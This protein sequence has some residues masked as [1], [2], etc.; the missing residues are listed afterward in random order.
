[1][2][3]VPPE[4]QKL[5]EN[6]FDGLAKLGLTV[7]A[8][9]K[10]DPT[11]AEIA[12]MGVRPARADAEQAL[13]NA[14][15][16]WNAQADRRLWKPEDMPSRVKL[17]EKAKPALL[18]AGVPEDSAEFAMLTGLYSEFNGIEVFNDPSDYIRNWIGLD[19]HTKLLAEITETGTA[20]G[21]KKPTGG[22]A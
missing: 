8:S 11:S 20:S 6:L 16:G 15:L 19:L 17:W 21:G 4:V 1:M 14:R 2:A 3:S 22:T 18:G 12:S 10:A 7:T 13:V 9:A 5:V